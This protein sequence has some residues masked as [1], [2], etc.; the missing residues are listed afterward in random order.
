MDVHALVPASALTASQRQVAELLARAG[1]GLDGAN[2]WDMR[3]H[4]AAVLDDALARGNLGLGEGYVAGLWDCES[5]DGFFERGLKPWDMAAGMLLITEAGGLVGNY[6]GESRQM[7]QGE[8]LAG[9]PKAFA[10]M[11]RLLSPFSLDNVKPSLKPIG[12]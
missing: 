12:E 11:V 3:L 10:Q 8:V 7:E 9:N 1:I 2:P 5:L 4:D 6:N